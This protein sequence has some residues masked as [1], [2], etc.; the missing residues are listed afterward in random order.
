MCD[1]DTAAERPDVRTRGWTIL[2]TNATG[3]WRRARKIIKSVQL[4]INSFSQ[5]RDFAQTRIK[6]ELWIRERYR[7]SSNL[8]KENIT[9]W[10]FHLNI[11]T[12]SNN[13]RGEKRKKKRF[14]FWECTGNS[15]FII[16]IQFSVFYFAFLNLVVENKEGSAIVRNWNFAQS[17]IPSIRT[18]VQKKSAC[19][20]LKEKKINLFNG[21]TDWKKMKVFDDNMECVSVALPID[22]TTTGTTG[23]TNEIQDLLSSH[24]TPTSA[25]NDNERWVQISGCKT[26]TTEWL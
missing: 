25:D 5:V 15:F 10:I 24:T 12:Q 20:V 7:E 17:W 21:K 3:E 13:I 1:D 22:T 8:R 14:L 18:K 16:I 23:K 6:L 2:N 9:N 26:L 19:I 4:T 11:F